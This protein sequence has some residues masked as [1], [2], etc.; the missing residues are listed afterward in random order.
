MSDTPPLNN[1]LDTEA[2]AYL[3]AIIES[4]DDAII[5]KNLEGIITSWNAAAEKMY[6]FS[7][8]EAVGQ[9]IRMIIPPDRLE[10]EKGILARL[11]KGEKIDHF[12]TIR[13]ARDGQ[14]LNVSIT[15][16]PIL[17]REGRII[18][19]SKVARNITERKRQAEELRSQQ[20]WY[21]VTLAS[22]GDAVIA[23]DV[24]VRVTYLNPIAEKLTGW[25][26]DE[27]VG[28]PLET[29]FNIINE[30]TRLPVDHPIDKVIKTG[31]IQGL[32]NHT[33]LIS[34]DGV[35]YS[36]EDAA[37]PIRLP[38]DRLI[39]VVLVF[40]DIGDRRILEKELKKK[41]F[42]LTE[43]DRRK[44]EFLAMLAHEMRNPLAPISNALHIL[45]AQ[46]V[47]PEI[48]K[49]ALDLAIHQVNHMVRLL[50]DLLDV[51]R[52]THGK[53]AMRRERVDVCQALKGAIESMG[54]S[55]REHQHRISTH[56][57]DCPIWVNGDSTRLLQLFGNLLNNAAKYTDNGG[58]IT[59]EAQE[60]G[61]EIIIR[62]RD[63]GIGITQ[64]KL[65]HIFDM[66]MQVD[67]SLERAQG[68][69]GIGLTLVKSITELH[70]GNVKVHSDGP[71]KG[72]EFTIALPIFTPAGEAAAK[73]EIQ[74][75]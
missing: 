46:I 47:P 6:G 30:D 72:T 71:G 44:D 23:T 11:R 73:A 38:D 22:I 58:L 74:T 15:V 10:E 56:L 41:A 16:S 50:D 19:A 32:A 52:I 70:G 13:R 62:I 61:P 39:G 31:G 51:S 36:I 54:P 25:P 69:L 7:A 40:H 53:I 34:R 18:G 26:L 68:G 29:I 27:A 65:P 42:L 43:K 12:E 60:C 67:S 48:Q 17:D 66:F 4:S 28:K 20:E 57:P 14:M 45:N 35:E 9:S 64:E 59:V 8:Q 55:I 5:S 49:H 1:T 63:N 75:A 37:A 21:Q 24:N 33:V 2:K 3:A